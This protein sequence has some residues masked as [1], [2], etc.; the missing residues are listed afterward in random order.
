MSPDIAKCPPV[1]D[2]WVRE[3]LAGSDQLP[4]RYEGEGGPG[5]LL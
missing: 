3:V 1:E 2:H 4:A 5:W